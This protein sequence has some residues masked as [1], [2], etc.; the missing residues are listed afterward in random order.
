M[1]INVYGSVIII[2][3]TFICLDEKYNKEQFLCES[4]SFT[5]ATVLFAHKR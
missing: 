1:E 4:L 2:L 5:D 3:L